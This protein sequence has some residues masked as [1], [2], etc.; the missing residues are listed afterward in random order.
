MKGTAHV[1]PRT[2]KET[3]PLPPRDGPLQPAPDTCVR[4]RVGPQGC[5]RWLGAQHGDPPV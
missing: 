2:E 5:A 4:P 1:N 3:T